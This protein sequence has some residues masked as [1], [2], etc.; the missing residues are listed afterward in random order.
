MHWLALKVAFTKNGAIMQALLVVKLHTH[1]LTC[2]KLHLPDKL[3][4]AHEA[5]PCHL[6]ANTQGSGW[7]GRCR[8]WRC[9]G[10]RCCCRRGWCCC[11]CGG[12]RSTHNAELVRLGEDAG[13]VWASE[14]GDV[15]ESA[16]VHA[17]GLIKLHA[18]PLP[19]CKLHFPHELH[20]ARAVLP[21][22]LL[23]HSEWS[24]CRW[25][26]WGRCC[27]RGCCWRSWC[28]SWCRCRCTGCWSGSSTTSD[29]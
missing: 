26:G 5:A 24:C 15:K 4:S 6:L 11:W 23:P 19:I 22:N 20:H 3:H 29:I 1:P 28:S 25:C 2:R 16:V 7:C 17:L 8:C 27:G 21:S 18:D 13:L 10:C 12:H 14:V 9:W